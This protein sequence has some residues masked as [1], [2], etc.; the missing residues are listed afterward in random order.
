MRHPKDI[1]PT[2]VEPIDAVPDRLTGKGRWWQ[3][4]VVLIVLRL[5]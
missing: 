3:A 5:L 4:V 1:E 2:V